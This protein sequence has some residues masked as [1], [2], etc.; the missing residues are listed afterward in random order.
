[1]RPFGIFSRVPHPRWPVMREILALGSPIA[2]SITA[3]AGLFSAVS[4]LVGTLA[5]EITAAHQIA[6]NFATTMFMV[7]L[8]LSAATTIRIGHAL[9][10][11]NA[12]AARYSGTVGISACAAFMTGSAFGMLLFRDAVVT[13]YTSD[14]AVRRIA[15]SLLLMAAIFQIADG[16]QVGAAGALDRKSTR[17]NSSHVKSPY[18]AF[19]LK[20]T[21]T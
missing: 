11:G 18:A 19:C 21:G 9:G 5:A 6:I 15:I 4:I 12:P 1:Y 16:I 17:L 2:V 8:A 3:E 20:K 13:L 14:P 7:P 10:A